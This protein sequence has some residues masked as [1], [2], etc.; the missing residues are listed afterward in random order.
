MLTCNEK[1]VLA[2]RLVVLGETAEKAWSLVSLYDRQGDLG[3]L[4]SAI[5]ARETVTHNL[6]GGDA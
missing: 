4:E 1:Q 2:N 6:I 3:G 5:A